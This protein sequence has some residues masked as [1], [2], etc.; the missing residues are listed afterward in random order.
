MVSI[1]LVMTPCW[2]IYH[3]RLL[4]LTERAKAGTVE[5]F[6]VGSPFRRKFGPT[7]FRKRDSHSSLN[8]PGSSNANDFVFVFVFFLF[9]ILIPV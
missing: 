7:W 5:K 3:A 8:Y 4:N 2:A 1:S 9:K 6:G